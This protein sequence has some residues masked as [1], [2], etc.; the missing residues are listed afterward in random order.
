MTACVHC[1]LPGGPTGETDWYCCAGCALAHR[2]SGAA[3]EGGADK[4]LAR[5]VLGAFL[6]MGVMVASLA[7][8]GSYM[9]GGDAAERAGSAAQAFDG[10]YQAAALVLTLPIVFLL[11]VPLAA[12]TAQGRRWLS[13]DGLIVLGV[14]A[15]LA[16]SLWSLVRGSGPVYFETVS[17][18]LVLVGLGRWLDARAKER[19]RSHLGDLAAEAAPRALRLTDAGEQEVAAD[20]LAVGDLVR[21]RPGELLPVDGKVRSGRAFLDTALLTGEAKPRAV[22]PGDPVLAGSQSLDGVLEIEATAVGSGRVRAEVERLLDE[23]LRRPSAQTRLADR[24][25]ALLLPLVVLLALTTLV[26]R[27][28]S[29]GA[30]DGFMAALAVALVSCPCALGVATPLAFSSALGSAWRRG[31][32]VRGADIFE[33]LAQTRRIRLDKTGTLTRGELSLV[34]TEP[35]EGSESEVLR[36]AA[37]LEVGS[38]HPIARGLRAAWDGALPPVED[39][40]DL[41]GEGVEGWVEGRHLRLVADESVEAETVV[42]LREAQGR[43]L[44]RFHLRSSLDPSAPRAI[45]RLRLAGYD[46]AVLTGDGAGPA[47]ALA[48]A[49]HLPVEHDLLPQEKVRRVREERCIFVGDGLNDAAALAAAHVGVAVMGAS[50]ASL[51]AADVSLLR[52]GVGALPDLLGL[53]RRAV[54]TARGNLA[55]AFGYNGLGWYLAATGRLTPIFAAAAMVASSVAVVLHSRRAARIP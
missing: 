48:E 9:A 19:A 25:A 40:R 32:L 44:A 1:G 11:G 39:F 18:V 46:L 55:W 34:R 24:A 27:W 8:Y 13:A 31:M 16:T 23:A 41:P 14:G 42:V 37:A 28:R 4:L 10:L 21:V 22:G 29:H 47:R 26:L 6:A 43:S 17:M 51:H 53:A 33:R 15:A 35:L 36:L 50:P 45:E 30:E 38:A 3:F 5:V 20:E 52:E 12:S 49:L 2:L 7:L 54:A